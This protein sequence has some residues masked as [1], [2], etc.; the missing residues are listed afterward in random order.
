M[1]L[2]VGMVLVDEAETMPPPARDNVNIRLKP[3]D[4]RLFDRA[5]KVQGKTL[6]DFILD[7]ARSAAEEVLLDRVVVQVSAKAYADFVV[8]LE[9]RPAPNERLRRSMQTTAP[10]E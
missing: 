2:Q 1:L 10:W 3:K 8:R 7:A 9:A 5:A 6:T 4:R